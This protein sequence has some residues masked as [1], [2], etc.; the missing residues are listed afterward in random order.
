M[1]NRQ[2]I[3]WDKDDMDALKFMKVDVLGLCLRAVLGLLGI[4][5]ASMPGEFERVIQAAEAGF[6]CDGLQ[7]RNAFKGARPTTTAPR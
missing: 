6:A 5:R 2:V 7:P 4:H 3:E 1:E